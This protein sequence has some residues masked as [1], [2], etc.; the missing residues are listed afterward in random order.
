MATDN[1]LDTRERRALRKALMWAVNASDRIATPA[2]AESR[3]VVVGV[4]LGLAD[5]RSPDRERA[6]ALLM[7]EYAAA[8]RRKAQG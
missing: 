6:E 1:R 3:A 5:L 2:G 7:P 4:L 8:R